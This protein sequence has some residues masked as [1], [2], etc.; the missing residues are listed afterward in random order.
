MVLL[1]AMASGLPVFS[2]DRAGAAELIDSGKDGFVTPLVEW[3]EA[4]ASQL[5][6]PELLER[7]GVAAEQTARQH[8]W[9]R[10]VTAV[11][12]LYRETT[13]TTAIAGA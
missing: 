1:E 10:V 9:C 5:H 3:V 11:E 6:N 4:T 12:R 8:D 7:V 2:S 13:T